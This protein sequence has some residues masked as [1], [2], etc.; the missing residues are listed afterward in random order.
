MAYIGSSAAFSGQAIQTDVFSGNGSNTVFTL[1]KTVYSPKDIEVVVNNV[2][3][4]PFDGSYAV[5]NQTLTFSGAPSNVANNVVVT[6]RQVTTGVLVPPDNSV[7]ANSLTVSGVTAGAY[8]NTTA[9]PVLTINSKG[10][11]TAAT[12][13]SISGITG[14]SYTA[15][16]VTLSVATSTTT[17]NATIDSGNSSVSGL[18]KVL[19]STSNTSTTIAAAA[20]SVA[21]IALKANSTIQEFSTNVTSS[22]TLTTGKNGLAVGPLN[23]ANGVQITVPSGARLVIL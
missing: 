3:Q 9:I 8:G 6:Y 4:N 21:A 10:Q 2:Q 14:V 18:V 17:F 15:A 12:T 13:N 23:L 1:S 5:D 11:I 16:N 20:N 7:T 22:Y 19:D